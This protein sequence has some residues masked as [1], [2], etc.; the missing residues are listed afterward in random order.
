MTD[1]QFRCPTCGRFV[2]PDADETFSDLPPGGAQS[3]TY[4]TAYCNETCAKN[5]PAPC[6]YEDDEIALDEG[7]AGPQL[8]ERDR[9]ARAY[10][11]AS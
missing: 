8:R 9:L 6:L 7:T 3:A 5:K 11:L 4:I 1:E 10:R 2:D